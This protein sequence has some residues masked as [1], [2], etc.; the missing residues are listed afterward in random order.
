MKYTNIG[1]DIFVVVKEY[2]AHQHFKGIKI[3]KATVNRVGTKY[4]YVE[5]NRE[6]QGRRTPE[7]RFNKK[8]GADS[9]SSLYIRRKAFKTMEAAEQWIENRKRATWSRWLSNCLGNESFTI[10]QYEQ[11]AKILGVNEP[12]FF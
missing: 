5:Y 6:L 1:D 9:E 7:P 2:A 11:I 8:N 3:V 10:K 12:R 4:I